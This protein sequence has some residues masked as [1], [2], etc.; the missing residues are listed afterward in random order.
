MKMVGNSRRLLRNLLNL[1]MF[2]GH[3]VL[4]CATQ[5]IVVNILNLGSWSLNTTDLYTG[6]IHILLHLEVT[7]A[8]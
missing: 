1:A 3:N 2:C 5:S 4:T 6:L 7:L 8:P